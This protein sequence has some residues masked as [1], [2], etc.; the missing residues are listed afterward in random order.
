MKRKDYSTP[1]TEL[2]EL[3][4]IQPLLLISGSGNPSLGTDAIGYDGVGGSFG[5][6]EE[7]ASRLFDGF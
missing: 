4:T 2:I 6:D 5:P 3:H 1:T 7:V